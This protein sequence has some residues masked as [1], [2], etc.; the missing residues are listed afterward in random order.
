MSS[1]PLRN[2]YLLL[3]LLLC[4]AFSYSQT[5]QISGTVVDGDNQPMSFVNVVA[6]KTVNDGDGAPVFQLIGGTS[7]DESGNFSIENLEKGQYLLSFLYLGFATKGVSLD[8]SKNLNIGV[9]SLE[10]ESESLE[11]TLIVAKMPTIRKELGKLTFTVEGTSIASGNAI[12]VLSKTPGVMVFQDRIT[13]KNAAPVIYINQRRVYLS[14]AEVYSMLKNTDAAII[15]A[16][17]VIT[18][19]GAQYD[20]EGGTVLNIVTLKAIS[21][22]YKGT[23]NTTYEQAVFPKYVVGTSHF[24]KN[25]W[26]NLT[27]SY[28]FSPRKE[29][30]EQF[31]EIRFFEPNGAVNSFWGVD[32][33]RTTRS[34][35]HQG[36]VH[37][38]FSLND[39]NTL[40][41]SSNIFVSPDTEFQNNVAAEIR[42]VGMR[43]DSTF[44]TKS[45]LT[46]D[47]SNLSFNGTHDLQLNNED[48]SLKTSV[49]YILYDDEQ[50]QEVATSY[51]SPTGA[52]LRNNSFFTN[53]K[54][55]SDI[56]TGQTDLSVP[57]ENGELK[58]GMKFSNIETKS[59][60]DFFDTAGNTT[61][62]NEMLS[63]DFRYSEAIYAGYL[64]L[65][66]QWDK[67]GL[68]AGLRTEYTDVSGNSIS[69]GMVNTDNYLEWFPS[70]TLEYKLVNGNTLGLSY[71][72]RITR[73]RYQSLNP[74]KYFLNENNFNS[75]NPNLIPAIDQKITLSYNYKNTWF[76]DLY[77]HKTKDVLSLLTFQDNL[78]RTIRTVDANLIQ[79][80][81]YSLDIVYA[82][83]LLKWWYLSM[84]TSS[85]YF[86]N[87][88]YA[89]ESR[90][91][92]YTNS[93]FGFY[94]QMYN[95]FT[96][97]S[98]QALTMDVTAVYLS[99]FIY[100]SYTYGNQL[101]VSL[102]IQKKIWNNRASITL[103]VDDMFNSFNI[104]ITSRY[105]N[106]DNTYA[107]KP[108]SR[109][110]RASFRYSFG[111][112]ILKDNHKSLKTTEEERLEKQ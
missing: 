78:R 57:I 64:Q 50:F 2:Y 70:A 105:Y 90:Q 72:R 112:V 7:T 81:Q 108:E 1:F 17:E 110:F 99:D 61:Q 28:S 85:F 58:T 52:P 59:K 84:Y 60:L 44:L 95:G 79:D 55:E 40:S 6:N 36:E 32:F 51:F 5:Y 83:S 14:M 109:L 23:V 21:V 94:A 34:Y 91:E 69:V 12:Q 102:A 87:E 80:F 41:L 74:F 30:K 89:E 63:D 38:D 103:G 46:N 71:A 67:W 66:L 42:D 45:F 22:G 29:Y 97:S 73:P 25:R 104:P 3:W 76:F 4:C 10:K 19:P 77:Y 86:E 56:F 106:Q 33:N 62:F 75:G 31:D 37:A 49:N 93:T 82:T 47:K 43:L 27:A 26:L 98:K 88:F 35:G 65:A 101:N 100:G 111:N 24:Y 16:V 48:S 13:V 92:T 9:I 54:Q 68:N 18:N 15:K 20:A 53:A 96:L 8:L 39:K 107:A 11:E